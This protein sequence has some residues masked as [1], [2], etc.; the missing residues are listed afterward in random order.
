MLC[1]KLYTDAVRNNSENSGGSRR[2]K[3]VHFCSKMTV[4]PSKKLCHTDVKVI[5]GFQTAAF[6]RYCF[7]SGVQRSL[8]KRFPCYFPNNKACIRRWAAV[9]T[10][11]LTDFELNSLT[12]DTFDRHRAKLL[13]LRP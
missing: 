13:H 8:A 7:V 11:E 1:V 9:W 12:M 3:L 2:E 6:R 4:I 10:S 5:G